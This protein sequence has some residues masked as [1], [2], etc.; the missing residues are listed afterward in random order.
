MAKLK[1]VIKATLEA[2]SIFDGHQSVKHFITMLGLHV[3]Q[4]IGHWLINIW[5]F[6]TMTGRGIAL[7]NSKEDCFTREVSIS[8][9]Q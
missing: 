7:S 9:G 8:E 3:L 6:K 5:R 2:H 1:Q 4:S